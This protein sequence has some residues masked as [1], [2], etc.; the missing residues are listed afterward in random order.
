MRVGRISEDMTSSR[1]PSENASAVRKLPA[2]PAQS[3]LRYVVRFSFC[4]T[5]HIHS[6]HITEFMCPGNIFSV[7][8]M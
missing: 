4:A 7:N 2:H 5:V 6:G 8:S 3:H 1:M